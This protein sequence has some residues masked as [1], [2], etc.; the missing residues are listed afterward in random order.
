LREPLDKD[1][2]HCQ[3]TE[4]IDGYTWSKVDAA[5]VGGGVAGLRSAL[6][7]QGA[8]LRVAL[9]ERQSHL[10]GLLPMMERQYPGDHCGMCRML[11]RA[12]G[13]DLLHGCLKRGLDL[14]GVKVMLR[15]SVEDI[16]GHAGQFLLKI[17]MAKRGVNPERCIGCGRC[18]EVCPESS[19]QGFMT[20]P[21]QALRW[22]AEGPI[23]PI[24]VWAEALCSRCGKCVE[25]CPVGAIDLDGTDAAVELQAS[26]VIWAPG[27]VEADPLNVSQFGHGRYP[28]VVTAV[29]WESMVQATDPAGPLRRPSD[30]RPIQRAAFILC[31]GSR[32][33]KSPWCSAYCCL[34]A[35]R[36]GS[37]LARRNQNCAV[38]IYGMEL[39]DFPHGGYT[40]ARERILDETLQW[41]RCRPSVVLRD[42]KKNVILVR[43]LDEA[44]RSVDA[45]ADLVVLMTGRAP[46]STRTGLVEKLGL[47]CA[48]PTDILSDIPGKPRSAQPAMNA[49][50]GF[51]VAPCEGNP[52]TAVPG[53]FLAARGPGVIED[54]VIHGAAA[55]SAAIS[56]LRAGD[57]SA[58]RVYS[59]HHH[60]VDFH[61]ETATGTAH[62]TEASPC[63]VLCQ[64]QGEVSRRLDLEKLRTGLSHQFRE[65]RIVAELCAESGLDE[66]L[67]ALRSA[68]SLVI[69]ACARIPHRHRVEAC[70]AGNGIAWKS[71]RV[72]PLRERVCWGLSESAKDRLSAAIY[73]LTRESLVASTITYDRWPP[74][75][76]VPR[77]LV[78]GAG[79]AGLKAAITAA[80]NG[81]E[82]VVVEKEDHPGGRLLY[83]PAR[84]GEIEPL[85]LLDNLTASVRE[86]GLV[87]IR[88]N[89]TL[90][91]LEGRGGRFSASISDRE[92]CEEEL[93]FGAVVVAVGAQEASPIPYGASASGPVITHAELERM[94][95]VGL[96]DVAPES[97]I[98]MIQCAGSRCDERP[99][100]SRFCCPRAVA[101]ALSCRQ[102]RDDVWVEVWYRDMMMPG[103]LES[104]FLRTRES[105]VRFRKIDCSRA[106]LIDTGTTSARVEALMEG[107]WGVISEQADLVVLGLG[108]DA[109]PDASKLAGIL[110]I[111][112]ERAG[113]FRAADSKWRPIDASREGIFL[114]GSAA[115]PRRLPDAMLS[116]MAAAQGAANMLLSR[117]DVPGAGTD[118]RR[119]VACQ[120]CVETCPADARSVNPDDLTIQV[121]RRL[122]MQCGLCAM[123]C[124][125]GA[126]R[127]AA[128]D[129]DP[130][131]RAVETAW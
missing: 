36:Q 130:I 56:S 117:V 27:T 24:P 28:D 19:M 105:G 22:A 94:L 109:R 76:C 68:D 112:L 13:A 4:G 122:C 126:A 30:G 6:D 5:V 11:P 61:Q 84:V 8:G 43:H 23:P 34:A 14:A 75:E 31:A 106:P 127:M 25:V 21:G 39:R 99:Y 37:A 125:S 69:G 104:E 86:S 108:A 79:P 128:R 2:M 78:L 114:A 120:L 115:G 110:R 62:L 67:P 44:G 92:G 53:I 64:C 20:D 54:Q 26:R 15:S 116:G 65:I 33:L 73:A 107:G 58:R 42:A 32:D 96:S 118:E 80:H 12:N 9:I 100:C 98:I 47:T 49:G 113:F 29:E 121:S 16:R 93:E 102:L 60:P 70:L 81:L 40:Y 48:A 89:S 3:R 129:R 38:V 10:G 52:I 55:A 17:R 83:M 66:A 97:R 50:E 41:V 131:M 88:T 103:L 35:I 18:I 59:I 1:L 72:V 57:R 63:L 123:V 90:K 87:H 71:V 91:R 7:L 77:I 51:L 124:P 95:A 111:D 85:R 46:C 101:N 45:E 119:C 82:V 74:D